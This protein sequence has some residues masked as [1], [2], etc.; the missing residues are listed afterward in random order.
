MRYKALKGLKTFL[1]GV[2]NNRHTAHLLF[3][4][5]L[6]VFRKRVSKRA[7]FFK[8]R[9][10]T[11]IHRL[12]SLSYILCLYPYHSYSIMHVTLIRI[13]FVPVKA[14]LNRDSLAMALYSRTLAAIVRRV[15]SFKRPTSSAVTSPG[16]GE[17]GLSPGSPGKKAPLT[18][19]G[20]SAT[21]QQGKH[22]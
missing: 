17:A 6:I 10:V 4:K 13:F 7:D 12:L 8:K 21:T 14:N 18:N 22:F 2:K 9:L 19:G 11:H 1:Q 15:N 16:S 5:I 3:T 20:I